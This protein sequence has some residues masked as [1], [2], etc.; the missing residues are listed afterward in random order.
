MSAKA[1]AILRPGYTQAAAKSRWRVAGASAGADGLRLCF[2]F[3]A[4]ADP[5]A[6]AGSAPQQS[7]DGHLLLSAATLFRAALFLTRRR[8]DSF[9]SHIG[10]HIA[11]VFIVMSRVR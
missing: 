5:M 10:D 7:L 4:P 1:F 11:V 3:R 6:H 8:H 9:Q 2:L